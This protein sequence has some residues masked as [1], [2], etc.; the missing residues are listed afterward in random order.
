MI[1]KIGEKTILKTE[2]VRMPQSLQ[3]SEHIRY[4][5]VQ[6][7]FNIFCGGLPVSSVYSRSFVQ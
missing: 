7:V 1:I 3:K 4:P 2:A 6:Y 5:P